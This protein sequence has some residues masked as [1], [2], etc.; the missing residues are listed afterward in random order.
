MNPDK[1]FQGSGTRLY[2]F[3]YHLPLFIVRREESLRLGKLFIKVLTVFKFFDKMMYLLR[4]KEES[5]TRGGGLN[6]CMWDGIR[7]DVLC[8]CWRW[9]VSW[10]HRTLVQRSCPPLYFVPIHGR[11]EMNTFLSL[12]MKYKIFSMSS[13]SQ[14]RQKNVGVDIECQDNINSKRLRTVGSPDIDWFG[15]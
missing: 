14:E 4:K 12:R 10:T 8:W 13:S 1:E 6:L 2:N 11:R 3:K 7:F 15:Q 9:T 5:K